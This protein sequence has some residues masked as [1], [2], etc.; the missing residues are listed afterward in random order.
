MRLTLL[1]YVGGILKTNTRALKKK[2][3]QCE[4]KFQQA[5]TDGQTN[6]WTDIRIHTKPDAGAVSTAQKTFN[7]KM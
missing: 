5:R 4:L 7:I 6:I 3:T 2:Q 1:T